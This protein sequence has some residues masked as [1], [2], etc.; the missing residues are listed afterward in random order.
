MNQ[1]VFDIVADLGG[2][3]SAEHGIGMLKLEEMQ[4]YKDPVSV[5]LMQSLKKAID[6]DG[7]FNPGKVLP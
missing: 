4:R 6:P 7:L 3:F 2:S 1:I 5:G